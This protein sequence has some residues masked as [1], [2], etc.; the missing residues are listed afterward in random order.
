MKFKIGQEVTPVK[1]EWNVVYGKMQP[2]DYPEFGKVY[3][4]AG[5]P[6]HGNPY[7]PEYHQGMMQL[8]EKPVNK[9]YHESSFEALVPSEQL[10][11]D[12]KEVMKLELV[13]PC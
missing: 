3:T 11:E 4:V 6:L 9:V 13:A 10:S 7:V 8:A 12:L 2:G 1:T 5:Y